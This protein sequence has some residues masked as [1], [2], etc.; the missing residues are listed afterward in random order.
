MMLVTMERGVKPMSN[1]SGA[2][3]AGTHSDGYADMGPTVLQ[4]NFGLKARHIIIAFSGLVAAFSAAAGA[5]WLVLPAKQS[6]LT[7]VEQGLDAIRMEVRA[8]QGITERLT[9]AVQ[10]LQGAVEELR[11]APPKVIVRAAKPAA[12]G[13]RSRPA[14]NAQAKPLGF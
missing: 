6:D 10:G 4:V 3:Q 1:G 14:P 11:M 5:G 12:P 7:R 9:V 8:M 2:A 13:A